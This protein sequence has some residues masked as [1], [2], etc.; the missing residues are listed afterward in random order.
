MGVDNGEEANAPSEVMD[1][2]KNDTRKWVGVRISKVMMAQI[3]VTIENHP[4]WAWSNPNDFVRD[5]VRRHLEYVRQ[6]ESLRRKSILG[7]HTRVL[8]LSKEML[9][10][11]TYEEF[12]EKL[13][14][15]AKT[16]DIEKEPIKFL[17]ASTELLGNLVGETLAK[18][19]ISRLYEEVE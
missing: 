14:N 19:I 5:A 17:D 11:S 3:E 1:R 16:T 12:K 4:E 8:E 9:D 7:L 10:Y 13:L 2:A 18:N 15:V 6:Q